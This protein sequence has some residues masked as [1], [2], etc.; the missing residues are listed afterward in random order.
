MSEL[1]EKNNFH[2]LFIVSIILKGINAVME[3]VG[4]AIVFIVSQEFIVKIVLFLTQEELSEDPSDKIAN[5]LINSADH[6]S[7]SSQHFIAFYLLSHGLIKLGLVVGLLKS[8]LWSYPASIIV[9]SLFIFYQIIR[10]YHTH[11]LWLLVL[12]IFD[13]VVIW[14][15]WHEYNYL[16]RKNKC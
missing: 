13:L 14:L 5:Y 11:S 7:L 8:K 16:K 12:T 3:I 10:Y 6:F 2:Q 15:V 4:G 9:F 1:R